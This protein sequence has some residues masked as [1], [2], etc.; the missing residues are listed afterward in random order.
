MTAWD[1]RCQAIYLVLM[2]LPRWKRFLPENVIL[3]SLSNTIFHC[4]R[5]CFICLFPS[6]GARAAAA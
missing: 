5:L 6:L 2:N 4:V 1:R 3:V